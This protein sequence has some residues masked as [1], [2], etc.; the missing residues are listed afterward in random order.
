MDPMLADAA[1]PLTPIRLLHTPLT[2]IHP[3]AA[4]ITFNFVRRCSKGPFIATQLKSS[5]VDVQFSC[6]HLCRY[7]RAFRPTHD[8]RDRRKVNGFLS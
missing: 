6:V 7:K 8:W 4:V 3:P 1:N 5:Q 2:V